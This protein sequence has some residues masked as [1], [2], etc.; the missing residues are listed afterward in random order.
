MKET[1]QPQKNQIGQDITIKSGVAGLLRDEADKN[2]VFKDLCHVLAL[3]ERS[4][5][6]LTV[7]SLVFSMQ[8]EGFSH[9]SKD[10]ENVLLFLASVGVGVID[11][12]IHGN[13]RSL[14]K[15]KY[16]LQNLGMIA[17]NKQ[18]LMRSIDKTAKNPP[19]SQPKAISPDK[20]ADKTKVEV[21]IFDRVLFLDMAPEQAARFLVELLEK[22]L[23]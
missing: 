13:V 20:K 6:K 23:K 11:K 9:S 5:N 4:R 3:R 12:D 19:I 15:I 17:L 14:S 1:N 8:K 21:R 7:K 18:P 10:F 22:S 2:P 16:V